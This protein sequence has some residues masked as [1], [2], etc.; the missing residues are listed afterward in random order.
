M[1]VIKAHLVHAIRE[2]T[3]LPKHKCGHLLESLLEIMKDR[4]EKGEEVQIRGF[5]K[6]H[7]KDNNGR[8]GGHSI[9]GENLMLDAARIVTFKPSPVLRDKMNADPMGST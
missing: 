2:K 7:V 4:L 8:K 5:G 6:F 3:S 1:A 9:A